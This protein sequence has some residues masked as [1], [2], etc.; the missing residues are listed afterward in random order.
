[1]NFTLKFRKNW[2]TNFHERDAMAVEAR[3][4]HIFLTWKSHTKLPKPTD[5][6]ELCLIKQVIKARDHISDRDMGKKIPQ[7]SELQKASGAA[8]S[9]RMDCY[10]ERHVQE[11]DTQNV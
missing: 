3:Q 1:M 11:S 9:K 10:N 8:K 7:S 2:C 6:F 5:K 4:D